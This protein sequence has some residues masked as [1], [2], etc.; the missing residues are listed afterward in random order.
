MLAQ[1]AGLG[2]HEAAQLV[3]AETPPVQ[4]LGGIVE[5]GHGRRRGDLLQTCVALG[6][7]VGAPGGVEALDVA[8]AVCQPGSEGLGAGGTVALGGVA[9]VLVAD[10]PHDDAGMVTQALGQRP[11]QGGGALSV[12]GRAGAV[13][14]ARA[15]AQAYAVGVHRQGLG[16]VGGHPSG[17]RGGGGGQVDSDPGVVET[18]HDLR[19]PV[20]LV[21]SLA[22]LESRPGEDA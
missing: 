10:V 14:L 11:G 1:D 18:V 3:V 16:V 15:E 22:R 8:V 6:P 7:E 5:G 2:L 13:L 21:A 17:R 4:E 20:E 19:E 12:D 9:A